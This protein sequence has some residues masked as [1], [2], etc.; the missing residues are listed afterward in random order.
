[1]YGPPKQL[2]G[3]PIIASSFIKK[4]PEVDRLWKMKLKNKFKLENAANQPV[5]IGDPE[6]S[7]ILVFNLPTT[8]RTINDIKFEERAIME[9]IK[10]CV[11]GKI[12]PETAKSKIFLI[13]EMIIGN[14][15]ESLLTYLD[16][17]ILSLNFRSRVLTAGGAIILAGHAVYYHFLKPKS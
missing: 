7:E 5:E 6:N 16:K 15:H 4:S 2:E 9:G 12:K 3:E 11:Y 10:V 1:L 17:H 14:Q 8:E 13:P